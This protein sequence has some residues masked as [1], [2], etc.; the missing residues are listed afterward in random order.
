MSQLKILKN[1][2]SNKKTSTGV[3]MK[4]WFACQLFYPITYMQTLR[5]DFKDMNFW[6][7]WMP[8]KKKS[9]IG[10]NVLKKRFKPKYLDWE[11]YKPDLFGKLT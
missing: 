11:T 5:F 10:P 7:N 4:E 8:S 9:I 1:N 6:D 2:M 3:E